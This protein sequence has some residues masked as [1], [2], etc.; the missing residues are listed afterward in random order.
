[1]NGSSEATRKVRNVLVTGGAGYVGS[2]VCLALMRRKH[3]VIVLDNF[4]NSAADI[5]QR[6]SQ[7]MGGPQISVHRLDITDQ[8]AVLDVLERDAVDAVIHLAGL[9]S[10][11][12]SMADPLTY[13]S[14]N[15]AGTLSLLGAMRTAGVNALVFSSSATVYGDPI[16]LPIRECH[17]LRPVNPYGQSK[18]MVEIVLED[19]VKSDPRWGI[20]VLRYF[21]PA[22]ADPSGLI[23]DAPTGSPNNLFPFLDLVAL[24]KRLKLTIFGGDYPTIDGTGVRDYV[25]VSD[26]AEAHVVA[27]ENAAESAGMATIN[28]GTGRGYSVLEILRCYERQS[29]QVI[30]FEIVARRNGDIASSYTD[31]AQAHRILGW[32][33]GRNIEQMC[34]DSWR[35]ASQRSI[36]EVSAQQVKPLA[37]GDHD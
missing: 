36:R 25:H 10:V 28:L 23:G 5:P 22:G 1:M 31:Y 19:L 4:S 35:H 29:G 30:P 17:P 21:N 27:L 14:T 2:H 8:S 26:L 20:A 11:A 9:K 34:A 18:R 16:E 12:D 13:Y 15:V 6:V 24:G 33:P 3:R 37:I 32:K 7:C